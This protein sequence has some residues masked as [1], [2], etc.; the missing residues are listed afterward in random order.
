MSKQSNY[1][2]YLLIAGWVVINLIQS[3]VVG[4]DPDEAYYWIY[5]H[6]LDWG[7]FD[8]PPVIALLIW[9]GGKIAGGALGVRLLMPLLSAATFL[10]LWDLAGRP[11]QK[12]QIVFLALLYAAM[13]LLQI[14]AFVATPDVPLLFFAAL[15][16][17]SYQYFRQQ[18]GLWRSLLW[19][20]VMAALMY[21]K[22][23]GA[24]LILLTVFSNRSLWLQPWFYL[25]GIFALLLFFPHLYWQYTHDYPSFRYHLSGRD[26]PYELKH[27]LNYLLN[28]LLIFSPLLF[29]FIIRTLWKRKPQDQLEK[30]FRYVIFGFWLFF[31]YTTF[32]GHVEPQWTVILSLPFILLLFREY[33]A[34]EKGYRL[35]RNL[36]IASAALLLLARIIMALPID[37]LRTPFNRNGW[38]RE[39]QAATD[40]SPLIFQDSYRNP[41][42][43]E[44]YTGVRAYTFTDNC[45]RKNQYDIFDWETELHNRTVW[46]VGQ[47]T[48]ENPKVTSLALSGNTF[49]VKKIDSIQ[50]S[51]KVQLIMAL[52]DEP[53]KMGDTVTLEFGL[54]NPYPHDIYPNTGGLPLSI[55]ERYADTDC[56]EDYSTMQLINAPKVWPAHATINL[57]G[58]F[59]VTDELPPGEHTFYLCIQSGDLPPAYAS[60]PI[61]IDLI[62]GDN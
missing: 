7:Y 55:G 22:Y 41:A 31:F 54:I 23:H 37:G 14:Y 33:K 57:S 15:F 62:R 29:P 61:K 39:L 11:R 46:M 18:P 1:F 49:H 26:D 48:W 53:W 12:D 17:W 59:R 5:A 32:K 13:P 50:I 36:A 38:V 58:K 35:L 56:L 6:Q 2:L 47:T 45:Y 24:V 9:L 3:A 8:H 20:T 60:R 40:G 27:T 43:Y 51:Q 44:F 28:Q 10:I 4:L 25:A 19:G 16:F 52:P 30:T 42:M 34:G 21:S